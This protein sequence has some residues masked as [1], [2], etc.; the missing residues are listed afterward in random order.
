MY[1]SYKQVADLMILARASAFVLH[2]A[3]NLSRL[4]YSLATARA[5]RYLPY[6]EF[7]V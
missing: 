5:Q 7:C 4:A 1:I 3:S 6:G 2:F